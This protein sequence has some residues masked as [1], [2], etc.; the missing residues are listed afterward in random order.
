MI[1]S[2]NRLYL[3]LI[4]ACIAGYIWIFYNLKTI[5]SVQN[6]VNVC[7]FKKVTNLPCPS[8]GTTRSII[9]IAKGDLINSL[10]INP[11][12]FITSI[13]LVSITVFILID[14][15]FQKKFLLDFYQ[16]IE[17]T[18]KKPKYAIPLIILILINW[19]WNIKKGL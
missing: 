10:I 12:G 4:L 6:T 7:I 1:N 13:I 16:K 2:K 11:L 15:L 19:I 18:I 5:S 9:S 17:L 14:F 3:I 8:C